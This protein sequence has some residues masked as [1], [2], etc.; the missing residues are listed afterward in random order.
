M[1][2]LVTF[3]KEDTEGARAEVFENNGVYGVQYYMGYGNTEHF[4][5]ELFAG[6]SR[7]YAEDAAENWALNIKTL[8]G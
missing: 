5:E 2:T 8:N 4:K 6:K 1:K 7:N 3:Y